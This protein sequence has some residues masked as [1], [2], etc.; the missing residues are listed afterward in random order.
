M[1]DREQLRQRFDR[2]FVRW[3]IQLP[4]DAMSPGVDW[5]I[6]QHGW[7]IWTRFDIGV[8]DGREHL[9][10]YAMHRMTNDR[11][12]RLYADGDEED[13]PAMQEGYVIPQGATVA[14]QE[15]ARDKYFSSNQAVEKLLEEKGFVMTDQAHGSARINRY[16]QTHPDA[17]G[18]LR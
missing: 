14:E 2:A 10:Y 11:H 6:T 15:A 17:E 7:T 4:V 13:L 16:L 8:E 9:D 5:L 3:G 18:L 12:V 1:D